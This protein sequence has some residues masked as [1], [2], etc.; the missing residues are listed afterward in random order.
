MIRAQASFRAEQIERYALIA[1]IGE[2]TVDVGAGALDRVVAARAGR[3]IWPAPQTSAE[4]GALRRFTRGE[5]AHVS[6]SWTA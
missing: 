5:E 6:A 4:T 3:L 1:Q 2:M